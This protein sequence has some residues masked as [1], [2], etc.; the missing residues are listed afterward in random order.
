MII[1]PKIEFKI[2]IGVLKQFVHI[3]DRF[4]Q[5]DYSNYNSVCGE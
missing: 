1:F 2:W 4:P 3:V 5:W